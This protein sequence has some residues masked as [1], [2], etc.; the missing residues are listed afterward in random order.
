MTGRLIPEL[1]HVVTPA[2][3]KAQKFSVFSAR[4]ILQNH[5]VVVE[6]IQ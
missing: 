3:K 5:E 6:T 2:E 1:R 4:K